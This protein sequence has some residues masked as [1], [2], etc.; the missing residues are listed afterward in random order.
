MIKTNCYST[1]CN[2]IETGF[3]TLCIKVC[4]HCKLEVTESLAKNIENRNASKNESKKIES[5]DDYD[6]GFYDLMVGYG[7]YTDPMGD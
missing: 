1:S 3:N 2:I 6:D 5:N 4:R 7:G